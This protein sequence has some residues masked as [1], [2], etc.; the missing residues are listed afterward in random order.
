MECSLDKKGTQVA[1]S[2]WRQTKLTCY[3]NGCLPM[4]FLGTLHKVRCMKCQSGYLPHC[5]YQ[6]FLKFAPLF[7][8]KATCS[9]WWKKWGE[10][11]AFDWT[12]LEFRVGRLDPK[13][14]LPWEKVNC[15]LIH[16]VLWIF[17]RSSWSQQTIGW[18]GGWVGGSALW[19]GVT[20]PWKH[21]N[22]SWNAHFKWTSFP[23]SK[24]VPLDYQGQPLKSGLV[25][26]TWQTKAPGVNQDRPL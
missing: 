14:C 21:M 20:L 5:C 7:T 24:L 19:Y 26:H 1:N 17:H 11:S 12:R 4:R 9:R 15:V 10:G 16:F 22:S 23:A 8:S 18:R 6:C 25:F 3:I 13:K 2:R